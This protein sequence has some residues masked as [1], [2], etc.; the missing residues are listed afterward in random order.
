[1]DLCNGCH[2]LKGCFTIRVHRLEITL[3][4]LLH[5][6]NV[7]VLEYNYVILV[8]SV[9]STYHAKKI[10]E[11]ALFLPK[12]WQKVSFVDAFASLIST[13]LIF[14]HLQHWV[15]NLVYNRGA[16]F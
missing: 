8:T 13:F 4:A 6:W 12:I 1:M 10:I 7:I 15:N 5:W 9:S 11:N 14:D 2:P 16:L 3:Q